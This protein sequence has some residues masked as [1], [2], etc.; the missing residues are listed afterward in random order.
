ME[1]PLSWDGKYSLEV[2]PDYYAFYNIENNMAGYGGKL[3]NIEMF[4]SVDAWK[5]LPAA[6]YL[7]EKDGVYYA[8]SFPTDVQFDPED[9]ERKENYY[10]MRDEME[11]ILKTFRFQ[12]LCQ[13]CAAFFCKT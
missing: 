8:A 13:N 12:F 11:G 7:D 5:Q 9:E 1:L 3:F 2:G 6:Q 4:G 10:A